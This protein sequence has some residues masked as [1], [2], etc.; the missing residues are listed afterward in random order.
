MKTLRMWVGPV[1]SE[2]T[3]KALYAARRL[4]RREGCDLVLV[5]PKKSRRQHESGDYFLTT[6]AGE[7]WPCVDIVS[8][9]E[10]PDAVAGATAI[11]LDEPFMLE[12]QHLIFPMVQKARETADI[13]ISTITATSEMEVISEGIAFLMAVADDVISCKADCD[14]CGHLSAASRSWHLAGPKS[15]KIVVGGEESYAPRCPECYNMEL[16]RAC[17]PWR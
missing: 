3:T 2:K 10:L 12:E 17:A 1:A 13:L 16:E 9:Q 7:R 8:V 4:V 11:W 5:R 15:E 6:K 14:P